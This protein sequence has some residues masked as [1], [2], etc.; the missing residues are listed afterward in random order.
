MVPELDKTVSQD[1]IHAALDKNPLKQPVWH[2]PAPGGLFAAPGGVR[3][4][5]GE[6]FPLKES[7]LGVDVFDR[8]ADWDPRETRIVR[9]EA[10]RL[11]KR[12]ARYYETDG[13]D[14][15]VRIDL[16]VGTYMPV[17]QPS[18]S[19]GFR[20]ALTCAR[21]ILRKNSVQTTKRNASSCRIRS[22]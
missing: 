1:E 15:K 21:R 9:Q 8:P 6:L 12:L 17:F 16:P 4:S 10:A 14:D 22:W 11:R 5:A 3:R 20:R 2:R 19:F 13:I 7:V 18:G